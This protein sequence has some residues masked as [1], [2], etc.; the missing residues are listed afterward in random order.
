MRRAAVIVSSD[1][2]DTA[3]MIHVGLYRNIFQQA[4]SGISP[5][6]QHAYELSEGK[7]SRVSVEYKPG[8]ESDG[9][10]IEWKIDGHLAWRMNA[11]AVG[12]DERAGIGARMISEEPQYIVRL[13]SLSRSSSWR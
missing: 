9:A 1:R 7:F 13:P 5:A 6:N 4:A 2:A 11:A 10:F 8:Y 3:D 12:P